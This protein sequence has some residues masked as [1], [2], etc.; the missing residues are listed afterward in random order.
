MT[1]RGISREMGISTKTVRRLIA[2]PE[3]PRNRVDNRRPGALKSPMLQPYV[4]H[5]QDRW[6]A[7][8]TNVSQLFREIGELGY[9]GSVSLL[10]QTLYSW[11][12]PRPPKKERHKFERMTRRLSLRWLCLR[13]PDQ[14]KPDERKVLDKLLVRDVELAL[15]YS[16]VQRFREVV[17]SRSVAQLESWLNDAKASN[18]PTFVN[19]GLTLP[20]SNGPVEGHVTKVKLIKRS[21][22][23]R[24]KFDL[25]RIRVLAG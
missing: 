9:P 3:P 2:S 22:Y 19:A 4:T 14:L 18:L 12:P 24:A 25:L 8:C 1:I 16:L 21:G 17:S 7:G 15:G 6:Q 23:G 5:L 20:W 11:R 10:R 13:P